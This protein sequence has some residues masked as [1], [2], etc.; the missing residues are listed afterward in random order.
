MKLQ[1]I[2]KVLVVGTLIGT[3][4]VYAA[5]I[6][7]SVS[8]AGVVT[9]NEPTNA[10][11]SDRCTVDLQSLRLNILKL[12][13]CKSEPNASNP[14]DGL[15]DKCIFIADYESQGGTLV[16]VTPTSGMTLPNL[17]L[18]LLT[19][20][21]YTH[22]VLIKSPY[23]EN[24]VSFQFAASQTGYNGGAGNYCFTK[25]GA[26][27]VGNANSSQLSVICQSSASA[28][29][30][31]GWARK[32]HIGFDTSIN[33]KDHTNGNR[34]YLVKSD[35]TLAANAGEIAEMIAVAYFSTPQTL[36]ARTRNIDLGLQLTGL[37]Q[38]EW[39]DQ[40]VNTMRSKDFDFRV[41]FSE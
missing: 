30:D 39:R 33:R 34:S 19:E 8:S 6:T 10:G 13:L 14:G 40:K 23:V 12:G 28:P 17:N 9:V 4:S 5:E 21:T 38:I 35:R 31:Y 26:V 16:E 22:L 15:T 18:S 2:L 11:T 1:S 32:P 20:G 3:S 27:R 7:C 37:G 29:S 25:S 24:K 36:T 41:T